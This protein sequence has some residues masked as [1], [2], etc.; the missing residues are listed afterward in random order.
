V[1]CVG[2]NAAAHLVAPYY[3][4][5][6]DALRRVA[7]PPMAAVHSAYK[8]ADVSHP[9]NGFGGLNPKVEKR[10]CAGHIWSSSVFDNRCPDDEVLFTSFVGGATGAQSRSDGQPGVNNAQRPD[11]VIYANVHQ[12]L[13]RSFGIRAAAPVFKGIYRWPRA[14]PQYDVNIVAVKQLVDGIEADNV[15]VCANWYGGLSLSDCLGKARALGGQLAAN[16]L[17]NKF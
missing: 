7:Y 9:L 8:R 16:S 3:G 4:E 10:F 1:L 17:I 13:A 12:E 5:L 14:I 11:E 6:A 15:R 2:A